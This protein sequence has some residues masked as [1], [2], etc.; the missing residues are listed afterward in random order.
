MCLAPAE[1]LISGIPVLVTFVLWLIFKIH[2]DHCAVVADILLS[3]VDYFS[4]VVG[5]W[6][7]F[8]GFSCGYYCVVVYFW[9]SCDSC[10]C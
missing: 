5:I 8:V 1:W 7:S 6:D 2:V 3:C 4:V 9:D 10:I